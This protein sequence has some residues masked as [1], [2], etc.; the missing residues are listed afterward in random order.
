MYVSLVASIEQNIK[1]L[2]IMS[3][4]FICLA[5]LHISCNFSP[6]IQSVIPMHE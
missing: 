5:T 1:F 6:Q 4:I 2:A 3:A